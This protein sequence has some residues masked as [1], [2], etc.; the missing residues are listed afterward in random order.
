M[1]KLIYSPGSCAISVH[2]VLEEIGIPFETQSV[3][4]KQGGTQTEEY[5]RMNPK[6]K[7]PVLILE[8]GTVMTEKPVLLQYLATRYPE[9]G[10]LPNSMAEM[11]EALQICEYSANTVHNF[12]HTRMLRPQYFS[13]VESEWPAI[14]SAGEAILKKS[15]TLLDERLQGREFFYDRFSIADATLFFDTLYASRARVEMPPAVRSHF[16]RMITRPSVKAVMTR[17]GLDWGKFI[18]A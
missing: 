4:T 15:F 8:D 14:R 17:E 6:G 3:D 9:Y 18:P 11:F 1:I 10:L 7:V 12:A 2:I 5:L 13:S 16:D